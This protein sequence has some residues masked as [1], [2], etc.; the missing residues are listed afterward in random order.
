MRLKWDQTG[1]RKFQ[2]GCDHGVLY[3][4]KDGVYPEGVSWSG[5][6]GVTQNPGGAEE[7]AIY[8]DNIKYLGLL[9]AETFGATIECLWYPDEFS[10]CNGETQ[11]GIGVSIGQQRR[12]TFGFSWRTKIGNDTEGEDHGYMIHLAYG[13]KASPSDISN[14]TINESPDAAT[15][16]YTVTTTPVNVEGKDK[17]GKAYKPTAH[18]TINS[19]E[20]N[21]PDFTLDFLGIFERILYGADEDDA[22]MEKIF[23]STEEN[24]EYYIFRKYFKEST[25]AVGNY[26]VNGRL[27]L[28]DEVIDFFSHVGRG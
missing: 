12:K 3:Q 25:S 4:Q 14:E 26:S 15:L 7:N 24:D 22:L 23:T 21:D 5:L 1:E 28:P 19:T 10:E 2:T 9:S 11:V 27:P 18:I 17:D 8:A 13:C 6:T 20:L 16:S